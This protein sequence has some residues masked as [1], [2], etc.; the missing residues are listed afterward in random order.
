MQ[1]KIDRDYA[2][3]CALHFH[4]NKSV[5][6]FLRRLSTRHCP[7][8]LLSAVLRRRCC[9]VPDGRRCR[10]INPARTALSSKTLRLPRLWSNDGTDRQTDR[11]C[12]PYHA[13]SRGSANNLRLLPGILIDIHVLSSLVWIFTPTLRGSRKRRRCDT[14]NCMRDKPEVDARF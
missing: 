2:S 13:G 1:K 10:S 11:P 12:S 5:F 14:Y 9:W 3:M 6:G 8:L 7:H 4:C